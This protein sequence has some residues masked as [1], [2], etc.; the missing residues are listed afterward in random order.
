VIFMNL[1][2]L[3][4]LGVLEIIQLAILFGMCVL[5]WMFGHTFRG[6]KED[7]T[8][9]R[10]YVHGVVGPEP[11]AESGLDVEHTCGYSLGSL[12]D[13][14]ASRRIGHEREP[15]AGGVRDYRRLTPVE[16]GILSDYCYGDLRFP[17]PTKPTLDQLDELRERSDADRAARRA[18][19]T[20]ERGVVNKPILKIRS[21]G[22]SSPGHSTFVR[23]GV[24][25]PH[26]SRNER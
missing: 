16:R 23:L 17:C 26:G 9:S 21:S 4:W 13:K 5:F 11:G 6:G 15:D 18:G 3:E 7:E 1:S 10:Y 24:D 2:W 14:L 19:Q 25:K 20:G 22:A 12:V 8:D